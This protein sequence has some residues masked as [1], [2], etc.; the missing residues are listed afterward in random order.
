M[1]PVMPDGRVVLLKRKIDPAKGRWSYPAGY[2]EMGETVREAAERET[3]EEIRTRVKA[4]ELL[5]VYS[6]RDA[7][8][9]T[10]V[11][12]GDLLNGQDPSPGHEAQD[13][14]AF[15]VG[16]IPWKHLAFRSSVQALRDW[17]KSRRLKQ[18]KAVPPK[19]W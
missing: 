3:R 13:V 18:T 17:M 15:A 14:K 5:G 10:I 11:Y 2:Q 12:L 7:G 16:E 4:K 19:I 6:Y 9:V 1:I 8:V